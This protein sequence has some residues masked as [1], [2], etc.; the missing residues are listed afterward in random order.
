MAKTNRSDAGCG[1]CTLLQAC[2][3]VQ[4]EVVDV[5]DE[6]LDLRAEAHGLSL[7]TPNWLYRTLDDGAGAGH[8]A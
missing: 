3:T 7:A 4:A 2:E 5:T 6:G 1:V 8:R